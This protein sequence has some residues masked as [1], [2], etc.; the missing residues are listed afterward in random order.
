MGA[1]LEHVT[2]V[3][4][5]F[6]AG[7]AFYDAVFGALG[8]ERAAEFGDE[9]EDDAAVEAAAWAN[10]D[11]RTLLW[12]VTGSPATR[13]THLTVRAGSRAEVDGFFTAAC[14]AG[15]VARTAPRRWAIYRRGTVSAAVVD[16]D[17][18]TVEVVAPE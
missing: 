10:A 11:G 13:G 18:N 14:A 16:P 12:L 8:V 15:G 17:G 5:D 7:V 9:E 2:L 6:A 3:T 4:A 1:D